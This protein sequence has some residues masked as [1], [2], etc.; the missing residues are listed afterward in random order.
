MSRL[1]HTLVVLGSALVGCGARS[2]D[3]SVALDEPNASTTDSTSQSSGTSAPRA[4]PPAE[5]SEP[6]QTE[7]EPAQTE[8]EPTL[9]E[10]EPSSANAEPAPAEPVP[11]S[12]ST[13]IDTT[14][15]DFPSDCPSEQW[16]CGVAGCNREDSC[17][18]PSGDPANPP[19]PAPVESS[20]ECDLEAPASPEQCAEGQV[21]T[22]LYGAFE[23]PDGSTQ[24]L[25]YDCQCLPSDPST[26]SVSCDQHPNANEEARGS[27]AGEVGAVPLWCGNCALPL[28]R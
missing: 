16:T 3:D 18:A 2:N 8:P 23:A 17:Y 28:I 11:S 5:P 1:Y 6:A 26:G 14:V 12:T 24:A 4:P 15:G 25:P 7:P 13:E 19:C 9:T 22:C 20:C 10:P 27:S 21:Y